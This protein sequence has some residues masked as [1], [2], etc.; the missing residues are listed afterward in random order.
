MS[1]HKEYK[2]DVDVECSASSPDLGRQR[3]QLMIFINITILTIYFVTH[4]LILI[5]IIALPLQYRFLV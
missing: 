2:D 5:C 1:E 3:N 4:Y